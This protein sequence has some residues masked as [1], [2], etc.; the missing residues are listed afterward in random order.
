MI[1]W[2]T[3]LKIRPLFHISLWLLAPLMGQDL[4]YYIDQAYQ[5]NTEEII[6][7]FPQLQRQFPEDGG[8][9]YL[10][11][12]IN[13]DGDKAVELFRKVE[14][15]YP[16]SPFTDDALLKVGEYLYARGLYGQA[17]RQLKKIPVHYP[18]S[19]LVYP[20][21]RLFLNAVL[22]TGNQDTALFYAKVFARKYPEMKFNLETGRA[23]LA[24]IEPPSA[25]ADGGP[26]LPPQLPQTDQT[27]PAAPP[28]TEPVP[29]SFKL[30]VGAFS[31]RENAVRQKERLEALNYKVVIHILENRDPVLHVVMV[32]G[33][34]SR[35]AAESAGKFLEQNYGMGDYM[36][37]A[38]D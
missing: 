10:E 25:R 9:L 11:A 17:A 34:G 26:S 1:L 35:E 6:R 28:P 3:S 13:P 21:I 15:L 18:R 16:T 14:Q 5:G 23:E 33:F 37:I 12:L 27:R 4:S 32:E 7:I 2:R 19:D 29:G 31:V 30:Q 20:S 36:I 22:A 24:P 38:P 8:L